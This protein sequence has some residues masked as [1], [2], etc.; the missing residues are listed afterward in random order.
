MGYA[1]AAV[2]AALVFLAVSL[3]IG[4]MFTAERHDLG[5]YRALGFTSQALRLQFA[6]RFFLVALGGCAAGAT[7]TALGG[8][9]LMG[10]L[11]G[12]FG[13]SKFAIDTNPLMVGGLTLGLAGAAVRPVRLRSSPST[14]IRSWWA[15]SRWAWPRCS[16]SPPT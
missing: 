3:I 15:A 12:L 1:M 2:A 7:V 14:R 13:V 9:W 11:F 16:W 4:R 10:Q 8:S 6:L 5:V